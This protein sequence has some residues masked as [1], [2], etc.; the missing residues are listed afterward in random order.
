ML[1]SSEKDFHN[2]AT[3]ADMERYIASP[4]F[5]SQLRSQF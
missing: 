4:G 3:A 2:P 5:R 1:P